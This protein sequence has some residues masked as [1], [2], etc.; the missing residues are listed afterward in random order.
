MATS[1]T[2]QE[3]IV[4]YRASI[5]TFFYD[6][7]LTWLPSE[8]LGYDV[9]KFLRLLII[10]AGYI[11]IRKLILRHQII[12]AKKAQFE[13]TISENEEAVDD[14]FG[15]GEKID[16]DAQSSGVKEAGWGWGQKTRRNIKTKQQQMLEAIQKQQESD[17]ED[18]ADLLED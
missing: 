18:I 2:L 11:L 12:R 1:L 7:L 14:L 9:K 8:L 15:K 10:V 6:L 3:L 16:D 17:D 4:F 5:P 13:K